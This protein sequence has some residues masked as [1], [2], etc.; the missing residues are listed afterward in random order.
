[1]AAQIPILTREGLAV[2]AVA[3]PPTFR[4]QFSLEEFT[5]LTPHLILHQPFPHASFPCYLTL[6]QNC[7]PSTIPPDI[8]S[9]RSA[10]DSPVSLN[11]DSAPNRPDLIL[12]VHFNGKDVL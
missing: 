3:W 2:N 1:M 12:H 4:L 11:H 6:L 5:R 10:L 8:G 9:A 7:Q